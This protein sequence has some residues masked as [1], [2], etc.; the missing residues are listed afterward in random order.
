MVFEGKGHCGKKV[1]RM[2]YL[3]FYS[4]HILK[5][6]TNMFDVVLWTHKVQSSPWL[7]KAQ[8][9]FLPICWLIKCSF[10]LHWR[11]AGLAHSLAWD[12][13]HSIT[14]CCYSKLGVYILTFPI[15][16]LLLFSPQIS[17]INLPPCFLSATLMWPHSWPFIV[18][19]SVPILSC[20]ILPKIKRFSK[21]L[22]C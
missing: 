18:S 11:T 20:F 9:F 5:H 21:Q 16:Q 14:A 2:Y 17:P 6:Y 4:A 8:V 3:D 10:L 19:S 1:N 13:P 15:N 7:L 22:F 12:F